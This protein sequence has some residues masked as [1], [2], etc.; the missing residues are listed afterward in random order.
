MSDVA[1]RVEG[2]SKRFRIGESQ[3]YHRF[4][5]LVTGLAKVPVRAATRRLGGR[6]RAGHGATGETGGTNRP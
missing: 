2:L 6:G 4:T 3:P 5:E 1:I